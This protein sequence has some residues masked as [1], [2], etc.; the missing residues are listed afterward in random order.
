MASGQTEVGELRKMT[1]QTY[2]FGTEVDFILSHLEPPL[3]PRNIMTQRVG[4]QME[5]YTKDAMLRYF[6]HSDYQ[7]CRI[8]AYPKISQFGD[9]RHVAP[10][11]VMID[12]DLNSFKNEIALNKALKSTLDHIYGLLKVRPTVL[13][14]GNGYHIYLPVKAPVLEQEPFSAEFYR[15]DQLDL[16][17]KFLRYAEQLFTDGKHDAHHK[18]SVNSCLLRVPGTHNSKNGERIKII[19]EWDKGRP[20]IQSL[21]RDFRISLIEEE[22][23]LVNAAKEKTSH[24][25]TGRSSNRIRWIERLLETP[26]ADHRKYCLW[27]IL[28]PYFANVRHLSDDESISAV[29]SWLLE[30]NKLRTLEG[31]PS[32]SFRYNLNNA[33]KIG[34]YPISL[35]NLKK[36][37]PGLYD[38]LIKR[39]DT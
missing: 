33:K 28:A 17:T 32:Y 6:E 19:Q 36:E 34:Y 24:R 22:L 39:G 12:L 30:C 26:I 8:S 21:L 13:W 29:R 27:R 14:T 37:D 25:K 11:L 23:A 5:V 3:F 10:S 18:P 38:N 20:T 1:I 4:Y 2:D 35:D 31:R 15:P 7:D 9:L 16:S